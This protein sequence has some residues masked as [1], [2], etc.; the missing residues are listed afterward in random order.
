MEYWKYSFLFI[1]I[2]SRINGALKIFPSIY[3]P[4]SFIPPLE[5]F[6]LPLYQFHYRAFFCK[7]ARC[8]NLISELK[9]RIII[10]RS[11]DNHAYHFTFVIFDLLYFIKKKSRDLLYFIKEKKKSRSSQ[12]LATS[13][14]PQ[15]LP[16]ASTPSLELTLGLSFSLVISRYF[17]VLTSFYHLDPHVF[18]KSI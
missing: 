1:L 2:F 12:T 6:I 15:S 11:C 18:L 14:P 4:T 7:T 8:I 16:F 13:S 3:H 5:Y 10:V 9:A 17:A